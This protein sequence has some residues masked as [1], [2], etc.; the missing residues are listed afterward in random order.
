MTLIEICSVSF[1]AVETFALPFA[2]VV[3]VIDRRKQR[4]GDEEELYQRLSDEYM[5]FLKLV[6][7]NADLQ[8]CIG[9]AL[10]TRSPRNRLNVKLPCLAFWYRSSKVPTCWFMRKR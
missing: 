1:Y 7:E 8:L 6:L 5:D 3:F 4:Q 9:K 10:N 2:I